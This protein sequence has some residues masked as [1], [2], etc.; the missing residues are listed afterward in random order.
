MELFG[1]HESRERR[2]RADF[3]IQPVQVIEIEVAGAPVVHNSYL[4][5]DNA[6]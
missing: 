3:L 6:L 5:S 1:Q 2:Q 4:E